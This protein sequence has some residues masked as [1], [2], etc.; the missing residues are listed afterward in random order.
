MVRPG[1]EQGA[2]L[3]FA[4][5]S[6]GPAALDD[7]FR[8][9]ELDSPETLA[10]QSRQNDLADGVLRDWDGFEG[11]R[12]AVA[13]LL[14]RSSVT[15]PVRRGD[16]WFR[17]ESG[18]LVVADSPTGLRRTLVDPGEASVIRRGADLVAEWQGFLFRAL[19]VE[20]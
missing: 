8:S 16:H 6:C 7:P 13:P 2:P 9:L 15:A 1:V 14:A 18:P 17:V 10:W 4:G 11:F 3:T 19:G 20:P 5:D 12:A